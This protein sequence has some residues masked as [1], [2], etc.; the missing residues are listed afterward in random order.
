MFVSRFSITTLR[1]FSLAAIW[2]I[3]CVSSFAANEVLSFQQPAV[4]SWQVTV[5]GNGPPIGCFSTA[6]TFRVDATQRPT[7][8][9]LFTDPRTPPPLP[10]G[11]STDRFS[12]SYT[13]IL[14]FLPP[15]VYRVQLFESGVAT[16]VL[17]T[18]LPTVPTLSNSGWWLTI[19][20]VAAL[21]VVARRVS[22]K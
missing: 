19:F 7:T 6:N 5:S 2:S 21:G 1:S 20:A 18:R 3:S 9:V 22:S 15:D 4:G 11:S 13:V 14:G 17:D 16:A 10:C 12:Y 8:L